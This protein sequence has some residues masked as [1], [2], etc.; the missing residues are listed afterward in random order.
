MNEREE[1]KEELLWIRYRQNML[2]IIENKLLEMRE[3]A[4]IAKKYD[5]TKEELE[6]LNDRIN[7]LRMQVKALDSES[8][9][10]EYGKIFE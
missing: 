2:D 4:E 6:V 1:L 3:L 9:K 7:N 5:L 8:R 10:M